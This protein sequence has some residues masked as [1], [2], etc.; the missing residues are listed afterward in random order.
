MDP[1][2]DSDPEPTTFAERVQEIQPRGRERLDPMP[3][4]LFQDDPDSGEN[5]R[6]VCP[7]CGRAYEYSHSMA[8]Y[9]LRED[10]VAC[11]QGGML[12]GLGPG[13]HTVYVHF[14]DED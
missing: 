1:L 6:D 10:A 8:Q 5:E 3:G 7:V 4:D 14:P 12:N 11:R 2:S 13:A 9:S